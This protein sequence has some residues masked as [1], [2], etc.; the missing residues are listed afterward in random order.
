MTVTATT[1]GVAP[2][3]SSRSGL[4]VLVLALC[5][6]AVS[7]MQTLVV[8]L[9]PDFPGLLGTSSDNASWLVTVTLLTSAVATPILSRLADM[10]GKRLM[11]VV[12]LLVLLAGSL[13]GAVSD[14]LV[15]L[16]AARSLQGFAPALI[17]IG[18]S[19][20]RD[21]L[22]PERIG[23]AVALMS[24]TLGIGGA[25]GL[26]L[27]GVIYETFGWQAVFWGSV[28]MAAVMLVLVLVV[29]PE[30]GVRTPGRFDWVGAILMSIALTSLLLGISKGG[31]WG[32]TSQW[33]LLSFTVAFLV[34]ALWAPWELRTGEPLVDLRTSTRRP[35]LFTN[36]ASLLAGFAMFANLLVATQQL[37]I[38]VASGVG[39]G[40][41]VT[42]AGLAMLPGG[43]LMVLMAPVSA[44]VTRRFGA[45]ITLVTGLCITGF[46]YVVRV[47]LDATLAQLVLGVCIVSVGIAVSFAAMPVLIMQSV[48]ISETAAANGLNTV[49]RSI[50]TSTC[51]ATVAAV[52]AAGLVAGGYPSEAAL[53]SMSWLAA[54]AAFLA[55]VVGFLIP[56]RI[57]PVLATR[58]LEPGDTPAAVRADSVRRADVGTEVVVR[59]RVQRADGVPAR[60]AV[61]SVLDRSGRQADWARADND[62]RWSVVLPGAGEYL[63]ICS[64]EGWAARSELRQLRPD[65]VPMLQLDHR[66]TVA[67]VISRGGWPIDDALVV[68]TDSSGESA[69]ATRTD[70]EGHYEIGLPPLGRYV[71][72]A[73]DPRTGVAESE[74]V[75]ISAQRRR[76]NLVLA[77][78][79]EPEPSE[80]ATSPSG[81]APRAGASGPAD[82]PGSLR[83]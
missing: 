56:A 40:L 59:G 50:G 43:V 51:S 45:R 18:I 25:V 5:G 71:L 70:E 4:I 44:E 68:L 52:F 29:V 35:V 76:F 37:Q 3:R 49:V 73:L 83:W 15:A 41:D 65:A 54:G 11:I 75:V 69:G 23:G 2:E 13:L 12:S 17:P 21:E 36:I 8:P 74:D 16:I 28:V 60:L 24:A 67:G 55:A 62:G 27:S 58:P 78:L 20:M 30:S 72:T 48:P 38:P 77:D 10:H 53:H 1:T 14:S 82:G 79:S 80:D 9:L 46:G 7:L 64:A 57:A 31:V 66:L 34:F 61:V 39:F 42:E 32:W 81:P 22:P 47:L 6:T 33:T 26:P 19:M 63:V